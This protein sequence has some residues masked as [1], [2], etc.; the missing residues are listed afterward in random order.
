[1]KNH[2][3]ALRA[4]IRRHVDSIGAERYRITRDGEVH[5]YG[6]PPGRGH[7]P[8]WYLFAQS[9]EEARARIQEDH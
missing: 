9:V 8:I 1:M 5:I 3:R 6:T 4:L 7:P 2:E